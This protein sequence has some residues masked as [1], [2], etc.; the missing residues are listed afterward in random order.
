MRMNTLTRICMTSQSQSARRPRMNLCESVAARLGVESKVVERVIEAARDAAV[1]S[2]CPYSRFRV[3]CALL[4]EG[5]GDVVV[6]VNVENASYGLTICAE[7][8]AICSAV[9]A[10][11]RRPRLMAIYA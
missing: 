9:S 6:G 3:S 8:T 11:R 5:E 1:N 10:G 2:Y 7:R 4:T